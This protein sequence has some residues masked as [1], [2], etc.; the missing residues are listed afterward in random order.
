MYTTLC[1]IDDTIM[2]IGVDM[3]YALTTDN[4]IPG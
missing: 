2:V 1:L 4:N 3:R